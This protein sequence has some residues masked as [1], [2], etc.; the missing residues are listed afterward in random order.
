M[1]GY[2]VASTP[3]DSV[4]LLTTT[5][6]VKVFNPESVSLPAP[7]MITLPVPAVMPLL[8]VTL[9][10]PATVIELP[11]LPRAP[12]PMVNVLIALLVNVMPAVK[13]STPL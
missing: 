4:P 6:P 2:A 7:L 11:P 10:G 13:L 5:L 3:T 8:M 12:A 9:P 1:P